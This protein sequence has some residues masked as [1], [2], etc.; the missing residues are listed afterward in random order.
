MHCWYAVWFMQCEKGCGFGPHKD[1]NRFFSRSFW[2]KGVDP[3][4]NMISCGWETMLIIWTPP[5]PK[6]HSHMLRV[7]LKS[8]SSREVEP[9]MQNQMSPLLVVGVLS[10]LFSRTSNENNFIRL[11]NLYDFISVY[12]PVMY[13]YIYLII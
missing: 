8:H 3:P 4:I 1:V 5:P 11:S 2:H 10:L 6:K 9:G 7:I 12:L 13:T